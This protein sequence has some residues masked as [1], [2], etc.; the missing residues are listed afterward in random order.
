[1][2]VEEK[3]GRKV[4]HVGKATECNPCIGLH[5]IE[6]DDGEC[7]EFDDEDMDHFHIANNPKTTTLVGT[8]NH[9]AS[10]TIAP[11]FF[12]KAEPRGFTPKGAVDLS[13]H[14]TLWCADDAIKS[15]AAGHTQHALNVGSI[16]DEEMANG[17]HAATSQDTPI[18]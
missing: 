17:W 5:Q 13:A 6:F 3:D 14:S 2:Q 16:W 4:T 12:P 9:A 8:G 10:S 1:M 7:N 11:G 18:Q 15:A